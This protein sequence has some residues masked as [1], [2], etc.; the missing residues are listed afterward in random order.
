MSQ[1]ARQSTRVKIANWNCLSYRYTET[2]PEPNAPT[3]RSSGAGVSGWVRRQR[4]IEREKERWWIETL[5]ECHR[6][7]WFQSLQQSSLNTDFLYTHIHIV[8]ICWLSKKKKSLFPPTNIMLVDTILT[9]ILELSFF[10]ESA[11]TCVRQ[12]A[13]RHAA[14]QHCS[15]SSHRPG[16]ILANNVSQQPEQELPLIVSSNRPHLH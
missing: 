12:D 7:D 3:I 16:H 6:W 2:S 8:L 5:K 4:W 1:S 10:Y 15:Q 11:H 14:F 13:G 9:A